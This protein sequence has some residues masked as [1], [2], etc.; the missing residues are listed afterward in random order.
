M[1][2]T[3]V[4]ATAEIKQLPE[5]KSFTCLN[6]ECDAGGKLSVPLGTKENTVFRHKCKQMARLVHKDGTWMLEEVGVEPEIIPPAADA[7][8]K[9]SKKKKSIEAAVDNS[10]NALSADDIAANHKLLQEVEADC[11][12]QRDDKGFFD[13]KGQAW[14]EK[15]FDRRKNNRPPEEVGEEIEAG[16]RNKAKKAKTPKVKK[17]K[18]V[19]LDPATIQITDDFVAKAEEA[20]RQVR[21]CWEDAM[22][23]ASRPIWKMGKILLSIDRNHYY[24]AL[25]NPNF[26]LRDANGVED[27]KQ[28]LTGFEQYLEFYFGKSRASAYDAMGIVKKVQERLQLSSAEVSKIPVL[29]ARLLAVAPVNKVTPEVLDA[30]RDLSSREFRD[31]FGEVLS[32]PKLVNGKT[33]EPEQQPVVLGQAVAGFKRVSQIVAEEWDITLKIVAWKSQELLSDTNF[34]SDHD[35]MLHVISH[36]IKESFGDE[37]AE[38]LG[39]ER[40]EKLEQEQVAKEGVLVASGVIADDDIPF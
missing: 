1:A 11:P 6:V 3:A 35:R 31:K 34:I 39:N 17:D 40:M 29:S 8:K 10:I 7:S 38:H 33:G 27:T 21:E 25:K 18:I 32:A 22:E 37:Y 28:H 12:F 14:C 23:S 15:E 13:A 2:K 4:V 16:T 30:A 19:K 20:A 9:K 26:G 24:L 36:T 5:L